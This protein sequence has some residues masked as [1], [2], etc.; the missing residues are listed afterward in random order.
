MPCIRI[1]FGPWLP[2]SHAILV[3]YKVTICKQQCIDPHKYDGCVLQ[4][5]HCHYTKMV[6]HLAGDRLSLWWYCQHLSGWMWMTVTHGH[7]NTI[8]QC[9]W[10]QLELRWRMNVCP[11]AQHYWIAAVMDIGYTSHILLL[12]IVNK[13]LQS[14]VVDKYL[15]IQGIILVY[16]FE[17]IFKWHW[18]RWHLNG[19][20]L[21]HWNIL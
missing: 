1:Q 11:P 9:C 10:T 13:Y 4:S 21:L 17:Y 2:W 18:V 8:Y 20:I 6:Q 19:R 15:Y 12:W 14:P 5:N 16:S 7:S 3:G